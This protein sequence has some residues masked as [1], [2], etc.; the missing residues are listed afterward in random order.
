MN[1]AET[2]KG[3][4]GILNLTNAPKLE[5]VNPIINANRTEKRIQK[6]NKGFFEI[7]LKA[8]ISFDLNKT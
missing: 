7:I 5:V 6:S 4:I 8:P 1:N 3:S 2:K